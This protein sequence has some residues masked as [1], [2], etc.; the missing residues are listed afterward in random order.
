LK[1]L[2]RR[3]V[4][5]SGRNSLYL[6]CVSQTVQINRHFRSMKIL[7]TRLRGSKPRQNFPKPVDSVV[8]GWPKRP[9][10]FETLR[11]RTGVPSGTNSLFLSCVSQTDHINRYFRSLKIL[12]TRQRG[13][14]RRQNVGKLVDLVAEGCSK[15]P[16][17]F[18]TFATAK[19]STQWKKQPVSG[20]R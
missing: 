16:G 3:K 19:R 17:L 13:S 11:R 15:R 14:K 5:P 18:E 10:L 1:R 9:G 20:L 2:G 7:F 6:A 4:V 12:F 8:E